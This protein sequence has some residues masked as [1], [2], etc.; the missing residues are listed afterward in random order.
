MSNNIFSKLPK[1]IS[2][3]PAWLVVFSLAAMLWGVSAKSSDFVY[4]PNNPS[5]GG[6][7]FNSAHLLGLAERQ[8]KHKDTGSSAAS[9]YGNTPADQFVRQL[10]NRMLSSLS[11]Q[12]NEAIFGENAAEAGRIVFGDQVI[13][14]NRGLEGVHLVIENT[15]DGSQTEITVPTL[16]VQ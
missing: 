13:S 9:R 1:K 16:Q 2:K 8:N 15:A 10:Q 3:R 4:R 12:V 7:A 6:D 14:F 5:F 11:Q